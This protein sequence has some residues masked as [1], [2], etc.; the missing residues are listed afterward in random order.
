MR[1]DMNVYFLHADEDAP[2]GAS[3]LYEAEWNEESTA[4]EAL[5]AVLWFAD[6]KA[7]F[8]ARVL[9]AAAS[10]DLNGH[11]LN[12]PDWWWVAYVR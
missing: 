1:V 9:A 6:K 7:V 8:R 10:F 12:P 11:N 2:E 5:D 3:T 4:E